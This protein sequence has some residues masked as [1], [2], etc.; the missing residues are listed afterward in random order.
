MSFSLKAASARFR[1]EKNLS[2]GSAARLAWP[3]DGAVT[4]VAGPASPVDSGE[5]ASLLSSYALRVF[6]SQKLSGR[7]PWPLR[8]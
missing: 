8:L 6:S 2:V 3:A 7:E 1:P 5:S 4:R